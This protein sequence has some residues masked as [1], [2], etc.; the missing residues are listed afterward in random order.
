MAAWVEEVPEEGFLS[1]KFLDKPWL[2]W[3]ELDGSWVMVSDRCPHRFVPLSRG[4]FNDGK[5]SCG[6]H[7]LTFNGKGECVFNPFSQQIPNNAR[8]STLPVVERYG[9]LWF[10]LGDASLADQDSIPDFNFIET[11]QPISCAHYLMGVN[12]ELIADN[13]LDLTHAEFLHVENFGMKGSLF[14]HGKQKVEVDD[15]GAIWNKWDTKDAPPPDWPEHLKREGI[16][17]DEALHIRWHAP[18]SLALFIEINRH[19]TGEPVIPPM[20]NPHI[21]TP[22]TQKSTHYFFTHGRSKEAEEHARKVFL[23][24]DE[25]MLQA[26]SDAMDGEDFWDLNPVVMPSDV[27]AIRA[28][29]QLL[30]LRSEEAD[31]REEVVAQLNFNN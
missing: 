24:E 9:A 14:S 16:T 18:A 17:I 1:R 31:Q 7:G 26:Q 23:T 29:R 6:Y 30:K 12:Y 20:A 8:L 10:W 13:L 27:A 28:R 21:L 5:I 11:G 22:E 2:L 4:K 15:S 3:R 25:P 19:D